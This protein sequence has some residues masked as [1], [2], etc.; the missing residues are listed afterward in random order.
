[1]LSRCCCRD[2]KKLSLYKLWRTEH[3][4]DVN[5]FNSS[6]NNV[7]ITVQYIIL[8]Y[9]AIYYL[10]YITVQYIL[11]YITVQ[12]IFDQSVS[13]GKGSLLVVTAVN[14]RH[15]QDS[16]GIILQSKNMGPEFG[17]EYKIP[18]GSG[19]GQMMR[20]WPDPDLQH[21]V[22]KVGSTGYP[23]LFNFGIRKWLTGY[24]TGH[25]ISDRMCSRHFTHEGQKPAAAGRY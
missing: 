25:R 19:K 20:I 21:W 23:A 8:Y 17:L 22:L 9:S 1:M 10:Y 15:W 24:L 11:Y 7:I 2:A 5:I 6:G 13:F 18:M 4:T 14:I 3:C 12:Y 16:W